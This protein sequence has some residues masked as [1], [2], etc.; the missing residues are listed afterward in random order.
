MNFLADESKDRQIVDALRN[1]GFNIGYVAEIEP[2]ISDDAVLNPANKERALLITADKDF[3]ELVFRLRRL[4]AGVILIRLAGLSPIKKT[5]I[6]TSII[7][8]H[9]NELIESFSVITPTG[10]RIRRWDI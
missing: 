2:S 4:S 9:S 6:V 10:I 7:K 1:E 8:K 3:G 5:E